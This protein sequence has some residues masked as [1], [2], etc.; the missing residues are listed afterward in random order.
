MATRKTTTKTPRDVMWDV[1]TIA[2]FI[3][4]GEQ[5][6]YRSARAHGLNLFD[7]G[8]NNLRALRSD[9]LQWAFRNADDPDKCIQ[10]VLQEAA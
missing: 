2:A 6:V 7:I 4:K 3:G 5:W 9:V 8:G 1:P 10:A